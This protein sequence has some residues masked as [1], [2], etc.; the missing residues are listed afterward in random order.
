[1]SFL[2]LQR[3]WDHKA[4]GKG[5]GCESWE[6]QVPSAQP[7]NSLFVARS[8]C[9][10]TSGL[11]PWAGCSARLSCKGGEKLEQALS[12]PLPKIERTA[13]GLGGGYSRLTSVARPIVRGYCH[14]YRV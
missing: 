10:A 2:L 5:R 12:A 11:V 13:G 4:K 14:S 7:Q 9:K 8:C 3:P 1:M 6:L